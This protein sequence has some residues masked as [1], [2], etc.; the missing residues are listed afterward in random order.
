M[1]AK[2]DI[3]N[4]GNHLKPVDDADMPGTKPYA[5]VLLSKPTLIKG[6][7]RGNVSGGEVLHRS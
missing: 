1:P 6:L 3:Q 5:W 7:V 2:N 4:C